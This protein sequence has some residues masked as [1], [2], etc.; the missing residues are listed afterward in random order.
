MDAFADDLSM[1]CV[2]CAASITTNASLIFSHDLGISSVFYL[3]FVL[4]FTQTTLGF[5]TKDV[6]CV[7]VVNMHCAEAA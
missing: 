1:L 5:N 4:N 3:D 7:I 6:S 2:P